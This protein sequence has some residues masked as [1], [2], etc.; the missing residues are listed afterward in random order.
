MTARRWQRPSWFAIALTLAGIALFAR[1]GVWQLDR[2]AEAQRLLSAFDSAPKAAFEDF[3]AV[4]SAP[5]ADRFPHVR[6]SGQF[7]ADRGWLR[8]EQIRDG[9]RGVEAYAA[10]VPSGGGDVLLVDR[11][12]IAWS[13]ER[14][15]QPALPPLPSGEATLAGV[16]AP[17]PG[18]GIRVG[19]NALVRQTTWPKLTLAIDAQEIA[20]DLDRPLLPRVLLLDADAASGFVRAWTPSVMP[21]ERHRGYAVQ[22]FAFVIAAIAIFVLLH[23]KKIR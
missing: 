23:Y 13:H 3:A 6:V 8:D 5:P 1:L 15:T 16:Y 19:G 18:N 12:W 17:F 10:F 11:G 9:K 2:A 14:G 20:A 21:P 4:H 7:L 22:W